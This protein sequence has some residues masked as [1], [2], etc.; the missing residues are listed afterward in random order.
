MNYKNIVLASVVSAA[1]LTTSVYANTTKP[2][3][4]KNGIKVWTIHN[5]NNPIVSYRAETIVDTT[6]ER[7]AG[8]ILDVNYAASWVPYL[9]RVDL[10]ARD[11]KKGEYQLYMVLDFPFP[12]TDRDLVLQTRTYRDSKGTIFI[13]N[14]AAPQ[15]KA[16]SNEFVRL[17]KYEGDWTFQKTADNKV[18]ITTTGYADPEGVIPLSVSNLFVKQQ[19]YLMLQKMK[20]E[21]QKNRKMPPLPEALR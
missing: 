8:L 2:S 14:K 16:K 10:M 21:L 12:L 19:P 13:K 9:K 20:V 1:S 17:N 11:D 3:L 5:P 4:D 7:A 6:I 15:L 18:K